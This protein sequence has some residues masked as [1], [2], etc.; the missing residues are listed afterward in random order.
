M[1]GSAT[2]VKNCAFPRILVLY[3]FSQYNKK[4]EIKAEIPLQFTLAYLL[5]MES[6]NTSRNER[7][8]IIPLMRKI[9]LKMFK[10]DYYFDIMTEQL[11]VYENG[12]SFCIYTYN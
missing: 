5:T 8:E 2:N 1:H 10:L 9:H 6:K 3:N 11:G 4:K 12:V 7:L